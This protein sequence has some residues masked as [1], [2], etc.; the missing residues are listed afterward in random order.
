MQLNDKFFRNLIIV[1]SVVVVALVA[2]MYLGWLPSYDLGVEPG[3]FP[4]FHAILNTIATVLLVTGLVFI[5]QKNIKAHKISMLSA[6][7]VSGIFLVS[8][9]LYHSSQA[10]PVTYGGDGPLRYV[11]YF[12]LISHIFLAAVIFPFIL[13]TLYRAF[14]GA[15]IK[16]RKVARFTLPLC[17]YVTVTGVLVYV[18][19]APYY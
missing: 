10:E 7:T 12:I 17:L 9:V 19:M 2:I 16:H 14:S 3:V 15:I 11:Y 18:F 13:F 4:R 5:K 8:Y 6:F 1:I